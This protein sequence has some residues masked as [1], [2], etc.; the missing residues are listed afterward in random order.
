M[1]ATTAEDDYVCDS[2]GSRVRRRVK[3]SVIT[4]ESGER[5]R[6]ANERAKR[7]TCDRMRQAREERRAVKRGRKD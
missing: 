2:L 5:E 4:L 7:Q 6:D 3:H 1:T